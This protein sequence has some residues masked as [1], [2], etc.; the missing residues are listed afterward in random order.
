MSSPTINNIFLMGCIICYIS[1]VAFGLSA[2]DVAYKLPLTCILQV[3]TLSIGFSLTFG[4]L[5]AKTWRVYKVLTNGAKMRMVN[6]N[7]FDDS[8]AS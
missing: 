5:I 8:T 2:L 4:S 1:A 6:S 3:W 7:Y